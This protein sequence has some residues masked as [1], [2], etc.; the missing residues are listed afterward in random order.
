MS[1]IVKRLMGWLHA[2]GISP[3]QITITL[4]VLTESGAY[5]LAQEIE[6]GG[7]E[8]VITGFPMPNDERQSAYNFE[9]AGMRVVV[10]K[11]VSA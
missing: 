4:D 11:K 2:H 5:R 1:G 3:T 9:I 6:R 10:Q 8:M 7:A